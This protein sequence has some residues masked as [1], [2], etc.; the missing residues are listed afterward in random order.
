LS[1]FGIPN[2]DIGISFFKY[3]ISVRYFQYNDPWLIWTGFGNYTR[4]SH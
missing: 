1:V 4:C 3:R 2:T